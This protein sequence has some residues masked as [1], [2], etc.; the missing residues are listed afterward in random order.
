MANIAPLC[1]TYA[2]AVIPLTETYDP[3]LM[4]TGIF[5]SSAFLVFVPSPDHDAS[6]L[7]DNYLRQRLHLHCNHRHLH[8]R[9]DRFGRELCTH[10]LS[11]CSSS[12]F[13]FDIL[14]ILHADVTGE[15]YYMI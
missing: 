7:D 15:I 5:A 4:T 10:L 1:N 8:H 3:T 14:N 9:F 13:E 12:F 6:S 2:N 11:Y